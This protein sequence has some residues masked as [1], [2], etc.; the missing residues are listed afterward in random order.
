[1]VLNGRRK[2][3]SKDAY[4]KIW[5]HA[6]KSGYRP[7][8]I[9]TDL[10]A[11]ES[12]TK[13]V[14]FV[15]REGVKLYNQSPFFGHV[16]HG[17]HDFLAEKGISLLFLG[18]EN[19]LNVEQLKCMQDPNSFLGL[20]IIGEVGRPF[21]HAMLKLDSRIVTVSSQYPGLCDSVV[22]NEEQAA[23]L[24]VQHLMDLGH[25]S[26]AWVGGNSTS[27][28]ARSRLNAVKSALH[29]RNVELDPK[30]CIETDTGDRK[31]GR[32]VAEAILEAAGK[33]KPPTAWICFNGLMARGAM[34]YLATQNISVPEDISFAA[35]D[36]SGVCGEEHPTITGA[37]TSP[38]LMGQ[39]AA[40]LLLE[41]TQS[42]NKRFNDIILSA[43]LCQR[44]STAD[45]PVGKKSKK[46]ETAV[47]NP[48]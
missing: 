36:H 39:I 3:V 28:R 2:G 24:L 6:R 10:L 25:E 32:K 16:Q 29:L 20:V 7:K 44:E 12:A 8:G 4:E 5:D 15:L 22:S 37:A 35:F 31:E 38:E 1:M 21:L 9:A 27:Q 47:L 43:D 42:D 17:I 34:N 48:L 33:S 13:T 11:Q 18:V 45:A 30:Y 19:D 23:D 26:F 46:K 40:E 41:K 14:G